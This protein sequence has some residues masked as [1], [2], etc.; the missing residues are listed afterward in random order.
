MAPDCPYTGLPCCLTPCARTSR[1]NIHCSLSLPEHAT[2]SGHELETLLSAPKWSGAHLWSVFLILQNEIPFVLH[3]F[4][5]LFIDSRNTW[6]AFTIG[7]VVFY[8]L[9]RECRQNGPTLLLMPLT[10]ESRECTTRNRVSADS[11]NSLWYG[12]RDPGGK[13]SRVG[14]SWNWQYESKGKKASRSR[15]YLCK[16]GK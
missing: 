8:V 6:G 5:P 3:S 2:T 15:S 14:Q 12:D 9:E 4:T 16:D 11:R 7:Q 10:L 13:Q 1:K